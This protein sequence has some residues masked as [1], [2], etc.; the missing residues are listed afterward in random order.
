[1]WPRVPPRTLRKHHCEDL[2]DTRFRSHIAEAFN[3]STKVLAT[4]IDAEWGVDWP[5]ALAHRGRAALEGV[6]AKLQ[7]A[8]EALVRLCRWCLSIRLHRGILPSALVSQGIFLAAQRP[9]PYP[10]CSPA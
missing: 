1:M 6:L 4:L 10:W 9:E 7:E 5:V 8:D 2:K 3:G